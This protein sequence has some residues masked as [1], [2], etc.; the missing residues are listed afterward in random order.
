MPH[1]VHVQRD[2]IDAHRVWLGDVVSTFDTNKILPF[3]VRL[4]PISSL[5]PIEIR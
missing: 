3:S 2:D 5:N 1:S 4:W